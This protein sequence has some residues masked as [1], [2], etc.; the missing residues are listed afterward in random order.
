MRFTTGIL[1]ALLTTLASVAVG[2]EKSI[3]RVGWVL[4]GTADSS[5]AAIAAFRAGLSEYGF[6]DG[7]NVRLELRFA[8]GRTERYPEL[9][10]EIKRNPVD[11]FVAAGFHGIEAA[12]QAAN[13]KP[14][15]AYFCG[16]EVDRMVQ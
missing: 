8:S 3:P 7:R 16:S 13:G 1:V 5:A 2:Q 11:V 9:F 10:A 15:L 6:E 4:I 14:V 12:R